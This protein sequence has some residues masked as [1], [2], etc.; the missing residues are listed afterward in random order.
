M[1]PAEDRCSPLW[2][3]M[4]SHHE[5]LL[6]DLLEVMLGRAKQISADLDRMLNPPNLSLDVR[7]T[8]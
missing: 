7:P 3:E 6:N 1:E 5:G 4:T 2:D 8:R